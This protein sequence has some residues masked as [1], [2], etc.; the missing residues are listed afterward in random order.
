M[1]DYPARPL[2]NVVLTDED[3]QLLEQCYVSIR[4]TIKQQNVTCVTANDIVE[5]APPTQPKCN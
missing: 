4:E 3:R 1:L 2:G 5:H